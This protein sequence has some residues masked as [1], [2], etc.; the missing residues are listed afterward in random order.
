MSDKQRTGRASNVTGRAVERLHTCS[1]ELSVLSAARETCVYRVSVGWWVGGAAVTWLPVPLR[2][3][4]SDRTV[5][6]THTV[7]SSI[8]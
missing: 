2:S 4:V 6:T 1:C 3:K 8:F 5:H 7:I